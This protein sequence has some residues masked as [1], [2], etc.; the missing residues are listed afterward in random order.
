MCSGSEVK[1]R[2]IQIKKQFK[3]GN[4]KIFSLV[5]ITPMQIFIQFFWP[6]TPL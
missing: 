2:I 3:E 5:P 1:Q 6:V 4:S